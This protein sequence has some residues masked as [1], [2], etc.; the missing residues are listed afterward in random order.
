[1][2]P[3]VLIGKEG[4]KFLVKDTSVDYH[5]QF[6]Y[7]KA[8][9]LKKAKDG[10]TVT[11]NTGSSFS[12]FTPSFL[13]LYSRIKRDAQIIPLKD[14]GS[15]IA[16]TGLGKDSVVLDAG[17]GS[18]GLSCFLAHLVKR[19][20]TYEIRDDFMSIVAHNKELLKL[21]NLII[22][23]KNV[24]EGIDEKNV[25]VIILD[26]PEPW[27]ALD[28]CAAAL[29]HGGFLV[30][31]SPTIPQI[32][33]FVEAVRVREQFAYLQTIEVIER[34]WEFLQRK[35]RPKSQAIGH[36]GFLCFVRRI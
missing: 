16:Y 26:L 24:Y 29:K 15:I 20:I 23:Q 25:D 7:V 35:I 1:M 28:S 6:G 12:V 18:G 22:K 14:I 27:K 17:A 8:S 5:T 21:K 31:Y 3:K 9:D 34:Q 2:K 11:T 4:R 19:M 13:D 32:S 36:S 10:S 33:D 30:A